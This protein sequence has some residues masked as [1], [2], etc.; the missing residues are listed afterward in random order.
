MGGSTRR[1]HIHLI[2]IISKSRLLAANVIHNQH[3]QM[4]AGKL[5]LSMLNKM[6]CFSRKADQALMCTLGRECH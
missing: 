6:I 4:L 5:G 3:I 2:G 1:E